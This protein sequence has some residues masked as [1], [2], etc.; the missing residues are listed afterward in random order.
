MLSIAGED[1]RLVFQG[2]LRLYGFD[3]DSAWQAGEVRESVMVF[4]A[5]NLPEEAIRQGF[6]AAQA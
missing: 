5:D 2:V 1:R 6:A 4:I 3:F